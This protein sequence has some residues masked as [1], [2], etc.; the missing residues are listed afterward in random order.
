MP[1]Q[2]ATSYRQATGHG[3]PVREPPPDS[4]RHAPSLPPCKA[5]NHSRAEGEEA[6]AHEQGSRYADEPR[7]RMGGMRAGESGAWG[8]IT[9]S[10]FSY[11]NH[12][13]TF[14]YCMDSGGICSGHDSGGFKPKI[15]EKLQNQLRNAC[16]IRVYP[17]IGYNVIYK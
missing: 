17:I 10:C 13:E 14:T 16:F 4:Q 7:Q 6:E 8:C 12:K 3:G 9:D 2:Q 1:S 5:S 15:A 11:M